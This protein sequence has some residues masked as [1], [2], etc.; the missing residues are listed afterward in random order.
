MKVNL[1][2]FGS[3]VPGETLIYER[4]WSSSSRL[5]VQI[6]CRF[7]Y[8]LGC[9]SWNANIFTRSVLLLFGCMFEK[10]ILRGHVKPEPRLDRPAS[11]V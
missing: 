1:L 10:V 6:N 9:S 5:G 3:N 4:G 11:R 2:A 8:H 7:Q